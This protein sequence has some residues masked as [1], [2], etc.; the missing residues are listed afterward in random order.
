MGPPGPVGPAVRTLF[1]TFCHI[2]QTESHQ[3]DNNHMIT[4]FF[5]RAHMVLRA[6]RERL[7]SQDDRYVDMFIS[8]HFKMGLS[9]PCY[10][11]RSLKV[12]LNPLNVRCVCLTVGAA[13]A[14]W[15]QRREG[16]FKQWIGIW[17]PCE[18]HLFWVIIPFKPKF[19]R[20]LS[21][22]THSNQ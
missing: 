18:Y 19:C 6:T 1:I 21:M 7:G 2:T 22:Q 3:Y 12:K 13:W 8:S 14:E 16:R 9:S 20:L 15:R 17:T 5:F 10:K 11:L 4:V